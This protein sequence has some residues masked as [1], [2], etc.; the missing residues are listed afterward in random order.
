M[1]TSWLHSTR[2]IRIC[3]EKQCCK[4]KL[5]LFK[6]GIYNIHSSGNIFAGIRSWLKLTTDEW[7]IVKQYVQIPDIFWN[8]KICMSDYTNSLSERVRRHNR[9]QLTIRW[10]AYPKFHIDYNCVVM[11]TVTFYVVWCSRKSDLQMRRTAIPKFETVHKI[12]YQPKA[13]NSP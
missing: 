10:T 5:L 7:R 1:G 8:L 6:H 12:V 3:F 2:T 13:I 11:D 9:I 4:R